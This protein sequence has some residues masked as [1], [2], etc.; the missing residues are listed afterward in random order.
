MDSQ[1]I[2][3]STLHRL[4]FLLVGIELSL[5][6]IHSQRSEAERVHREKISTNFCGG[7]RNFCRLCG[8]HPL[9]PLVPDI[10]M[11]CNRKLEIWCIRIKYF[12]QGQIRSA[13]G[14]LGQPQ[15]NKLARFLA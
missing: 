6:H 10:N 5:E 8:S 2:Q 3:K 7:K 14:C 1:T 4:D 11:S 9:C 15:L 13:D 12:V